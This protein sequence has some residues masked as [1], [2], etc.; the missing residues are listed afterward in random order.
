M[1]FLMTFHPESTNH[2]NYKTH[3]T[4]N[5]MMKPQQNCKPSQKVPENTLSNSTMAPLNKK[6]HALN[7]SN[8]AASLPPKKHVKHKLVN[9]LPKQLH[10]PSSPAPAKRVRK[11]KKYIKLKIE[12]S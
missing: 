1:F 12:R 11:V 8:A 10:P 9:D 3:K 7:P 4:H 5:Y 2:F 6:K